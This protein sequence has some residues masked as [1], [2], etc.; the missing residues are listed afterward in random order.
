M[1][2]QERPEAVPVLEFCYCRGDFMLQ[3]GGF[4]TEGPAVEWLLVGSCDVQGHLKSH[5]QPA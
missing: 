2:L 1:N 4:N 3:E 5:L